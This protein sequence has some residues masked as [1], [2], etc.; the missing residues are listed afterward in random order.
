MTK[1]TKD[2]AIKMGKEIKSVLCKAKMYDYS[3]IVGDQ[4]IYK[5]YNDNKWHKETVNP[6]KF[7]EYFPED[8][9]LGLSVDGYVY[10]MLNYGSYPRVRE[11]I[12]AILD[13]YG[14][15]LEYADSC[16][17]Y[18]EM[19]YKP[20]QYDIWHFEKEKI[21]WIYRQEDLTKCDVPYITNIYET[22]YQMA[23]ENGE[24]GACAIGEYAEFTYKGKKYRMCPPSPWQGDYSWSQPW[25]KIKKMLIL[26]GCDDVY[27]NYGHLD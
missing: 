18:A 2:D 10:E 22:W 14:F 20:E 21:T 17:W 3:M 4:R 23:Y 15:Y 12:E 13:N 26:V 7:Y 1:I 19:K 16:Y 25:P 8:F 24:A 5:S 6:L 11:K 9:S 27:L